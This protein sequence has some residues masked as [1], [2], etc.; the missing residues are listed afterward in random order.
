MSQATELHRAMMQILDDSACLSV[1]ELAH[2]T[3][4]QPEWVLERL[5]AGL[6]QGELHGGQWRCVGTTVVRARRLAQLETTF[7]ADPQLAALTADLMEEV[8]QL[9]R[10]LEQLQRHLGEAL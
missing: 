8:A 7:D 9:R 3:Q 4:M 10:Q 6:L 1:Q 2:A 5:S